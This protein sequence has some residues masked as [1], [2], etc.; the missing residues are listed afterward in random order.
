MALGCET[1]ITFVP[2]S[3]FQ[4]LAVAEVS[5]EEPLLGKMDWEGDTLM[6]D[7]A[8]LVKIDDAGPS[9]LGSGEHLALQRA[10]GPSGVSEDNPVVA[11]VPDESA[12]DI[13]EDGPPEEIPK[14][15]NKRSIMITLVHGDAVMLSGDVFE[16]C[17]IIEAIIKL[18]L[19]MQSVFH[20]TIRDEYS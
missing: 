9:L 12:M 20:K 19:D 11:T 8:S 16:V 3:G 17:P 15:G 7:H 18:M 14:K 1:S 6:G 2:K 4:E 13:L 10:S 5:M